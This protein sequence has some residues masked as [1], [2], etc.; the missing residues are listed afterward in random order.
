MNTFF[1]L[2]MLNILDLNSFSKDIM[3]DNLIIKHGALL[4]LNLSHK[5][6]IYLD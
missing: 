5:Y 6:W 2:Y 3:A 4:L 1:H